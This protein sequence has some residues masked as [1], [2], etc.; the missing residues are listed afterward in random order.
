MQP[1]IRGNVSFLVNPTCFRHV[2]LRHWLPVTA[3]C[4]ALLACSSGEDKPVTPQ[5]QDVDKLM[6]VDCLL[7]GQQRKLGSQLSYMSQ[8]RPVKVSASECE[9]RGGEYVA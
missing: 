9:I 3:A 5:A 8:R 2:R 1:S 7:P 4:V 6:I